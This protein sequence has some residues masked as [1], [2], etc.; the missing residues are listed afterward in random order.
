M[1]QKLSSHSFTNIFK[2]AIPN[3]VSGLPKRAFDN[4][5]KNYD[6]PYLSIEEKDCLK[7]YSMKYMFSIDHSLLYFSRKLI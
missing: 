6:L 5:V 2:E 4:C 3:M 7:E 1:D